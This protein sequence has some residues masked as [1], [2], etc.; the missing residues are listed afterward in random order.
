MK[1]LEIQSSVLQEGSISRALSAEFIQ[2]WQ[3]SYPGAD[4]KMRDVGINSPAHPMENLEIFNQ[5]HSLLFAIASSNA[6]QCY[7]C[8][9][10]YAG[11]L[12]TLAIKSGTSRIFQGFS[13]QHCH[14]LSLY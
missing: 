11:S 1:L 7:R 2:V 10:Y 3:M 6:W 12:D 5:Y 13:I 4:C 8:R 14:S 9:G